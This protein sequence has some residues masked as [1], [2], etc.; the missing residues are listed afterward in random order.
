MILE[1]LVVLSFLLVVGLIITYVVLRFAK[2]E[3]DLKDNPIGINFLSNYCEGV[4]LGI[5]TKVETGKEGRKIIHLSQRDIRPENVDKIKEVQVILD[6]A[7]IATIPKGIW[8]AEKNIYIYYPKSAAEYPESMKE[9]K[10]G[11]AFMLLSEIEASVQTELDMVK[12]GSK[13]KDAILKRLGDGELSVEH[14]SKID[15]IQKDLIK[16][17]TDSRQKDKSFFSPNP[18]GGQ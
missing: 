15:E 1:I 9:T 17:A 12:E 10:I 6:K 14:L 11:K 5:E 18:T 7:N 2:D 4:A 8:S 3:E 16:L 13:R